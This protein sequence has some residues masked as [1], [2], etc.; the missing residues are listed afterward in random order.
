MVSDLQSHSLHP[1]QTRST[2][3]ASPVTNSAASPLT[4]STLTQRT[5]TQRTLS[6][7]S[8]SSARSSPTPSP[9]AR[10]LVLQLVELRMCV[11]SL[12][13]AAMVLAEEVGGIF[14][15]S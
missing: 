12:Q 10:A 1:H 6:V 4:N 14:S 11:S 7:P 15:A 2:N 5:L 13:R 3:A 8:P 9:T